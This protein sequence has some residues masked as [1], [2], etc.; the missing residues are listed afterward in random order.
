V[1]LDG[2]YCI[3]GLPDEAVLAE[4]VARIVRSDQA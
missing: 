2:Q 3:E 4:A 1:I